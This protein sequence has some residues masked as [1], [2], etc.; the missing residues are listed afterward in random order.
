MQIRRILINMEGEPVGEFK[1]KVLILGGGALEHNVV[2]V[3]ESDCWDVG[4][5]SDLS[6]CW[7]WYLLYCI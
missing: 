7:R 5:A 3:L 2:K 1:R 4:Y 6:S